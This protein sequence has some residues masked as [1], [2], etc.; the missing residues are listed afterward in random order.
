MRG[1]VI[2]F[3]KMVV[4]ARNEK[5]KI[6]QECRKLEKEIRKIHVLLPEDYRRKI[7]PIFDIEP[8]ETPESMLDITEEDVEIEEKAMLNAAGL[9][10]IKEDIVRRIIQFNSMLDGSV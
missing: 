2:E 9:Q 5:P 3:N 6:L 10:S 4:E 7:P 8:D 1:S